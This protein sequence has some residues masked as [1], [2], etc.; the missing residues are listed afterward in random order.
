MYNEKKRE[1]NNKMGVNNLALGQG[2]VSN[3]YAKDKTTNTLLKPYTQLL[4]KKQSYSTVKT[5]G[6]GGGVKTGGSGNRVSTG[7]VPQ[8]SMTQAPVITNTSGVNTEKAVRDYMVNTLGLDNNNIGYKDG[9]VTY[10]GKTFMK[11][12]NVTDGVSYAPSAA[13]DKAYSDYK[14]GNEYNVPI[15]QRMIDDGYINDNIGFSDGVVTYSGDKV[16]APKLLENGV[17]YTTEEAYKNMTDALGSALVNAS[18]YI[19]GKGVSNAIT[20]NASDNTLSVL[21]KRVPIQQIKT[22]GNNSYAYVKK[23]DLDNV[24]SGFEEETPTHMAAHHALQMYKNDIDRQKDRVLN[25][26][27]FSYDLESDPAYQAYKAAAERN[28]EYA[29]NDMLAKNA[30]MTGGF[31]NSNAQMAAAQAKYA[32][33]DALND[34]IPELYNA[35]YQR[36][37]QEHNMNLEDLSALNST[38]SNVVGNQLQLAAYAQELINNANAVNYARR[39]DEYNKQLTK[40]ALLKQDE[41]TAWERDMYEREMENNRLLSA[42]DI[43]LQLLNATKNGGYIP[44]LQSIASNL[45]W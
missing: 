40:E 43:Y 4:P 36:Y 23:S 37:A 33:L 31:S 27:P 44:T 12:D 15:R 29:Y 10:N 6:S 22:D 30:Q 1:E 8:A 13:I 39:N 3:Q 41:A 2:P 5:G 20:Y 28:A 19:S 26:E 38:A 9:N 14:A 11:P 18:D 7:G 16:I 24:Y 42:A 34:R 17:S 25:R 21:G 45:R 32:H 35:A